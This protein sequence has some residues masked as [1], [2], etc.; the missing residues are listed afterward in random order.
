MAYQSQEYGASPQIFQNAG[1]QIMSGLQ[2]LA[3]AQ[4]AAKAETQNA[5]VGMAQIRSSE[6]QAELEYQKYLIEAAREQRKENNEAAT[7]LLTQQKMLAEQRQADYVTRVAMEEGERNRR[8]IAAQDG[9]YPLYSEMR[10]S[11]NPVESVALGVRLMKDPRFPSVSQ[12]WKSE[13]LNVMETRGKIKIV[14]GSASSTAGDYGRMLASDDPDERDKGAAA[15]LAFG[16]P[17]ENLSRYGVDD[18]TMAPIVEQSKSMAA[19]DEGKLATEHAIRDSHL[20]LL[21][22]NKI[23]SYE[24]GLEGKPGYSLERVAQATAR[25]SDAE[26]EVLISDMDAKETGTD[27]QRTLKKFG[28]SSDGSPAVETDAP[29]I[30]FDPSVSIRVA[31]KNVEAASIRAP[32]KAKEFQANLG[33]YSFALGAIQKQLENLTM[34]PYSE[35]DKEAIGA[36]TK[37]AIIDVP[38]AASAVGLPPLNLVRVDKAVP[39]EFSEEMIASKKADE[40]NDLEGRDRTL[41]KYFPVDGKVGEF[42][43][44][45]EK[46]NALS[47]KKEAGEPISFLDKNWLKRFGPEL[48]AVSVDVP[49]SG[50]KILGTQLLRRHMSDGVAKLDPGSRTSFAVLAGTEWVSE[51]MSGGDS[52]WAPNIPG[53]SGRNRIFGPGVS[54]S[55]EKDPAGWMRAVVNK[56][57]LVPREYLN[58]GYARLLAKGSSDGQLMRAV[59]EGVAPRGKVP[60]LDSS[61]GIDV[62]T[63]GR[64]GTPDVFAL[65]TIQAYYAEASADKLRDA[66]S[67]DKNEKTQGLTEALALDLYMAA[68]ANKTAESAAAENSIPNAVDASSPYDM[69]PIGFIAQSPALLALTENGSLADALK[70]L[71][72]DARFSGQVDEADVRTFIRRASGAPDGL[73]SDEQERAIALERASNDKLYQIFGGSASAS[74]A[75]AAQAGAPPAMPADNLKIPAEKK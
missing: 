75:P 6:R 39:K 46:Y 36:A 62:A 33:R 20:R 28:L 14:S 22:A 11:S 44:A 52:K 16:G 5:L 8:A 73:Y 65:N 29:K 56:S 70:I 69:V 60:S 34:D 67:K 23:L 51:G 61:Y 27:V 48:E 25:V 35:Q 21:A 71:A 40:Q 50:R 3:N 31:T 24:L 4:N 15:Y 2:G 12:E 9:L 66:A 72:S 59:A 45:F 10:L 47:L 54:R 68:L 1:E 26:L 38:P 32:A 37:I 55:I 30:N 49:G 53:V 7:N 18:S 19:F 74:A 42:T 63:Y 13:V 43:E 58:A 17:E 41:V 57:R 64:S